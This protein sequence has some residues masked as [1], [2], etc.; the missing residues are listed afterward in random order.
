MFGPGPQ[1]AQDPRDE[2]AEINQLGQD[3]IKAR[4]DRVPA[5]VGRGRRWTEADEHAASKPWLCTHP[6][7]QHAHAFHA[8]QHDD[9]HFIPVHHIIARP[10]SGFDDAETSAFKPL[11]VRDFPGV[12]VDDEHRTLFH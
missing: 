6:C 10:F 11:A 2:R 8:P 5:I 4:A 3:I 1:L 7:R 9:Y 12:A